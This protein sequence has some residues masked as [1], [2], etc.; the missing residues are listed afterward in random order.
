[1]LCCVNRLGREKAFASYR[2]VLLWGLLFCVLGFLGRPLYEDDYYRYL[3]DG[4]Q[5]ATTGNPYTQAPAHFAGTDLPRPFPEI[6]THVGFPQ[7]PTIYGPTCQL[8]FAA[9]YWIA[10]GKLWPLKLIGLACHFLLVAVLIRFGLGPGNL[11]LYLWSPLLFKEVFLTAH[12]DILV[13]C[14]S[15]VALY[16]AHRNRPLAAG[17]SLG[18]AIGAKVTILLIAPAVIKKGGWRSIV[19]TTAMLGALY[20]PFAKSSADYKG[21]AAFL[22]GWEFNSFGYAILKFFTGGLAAKW[23]G[24][25][26]VGL[27]V[28]FAWRYYPPEVR[29]FPA[30]MI[31]AAFYFFSPVVNPW[32]LISWLPWTAVQPSLWAIAACLAALLSYA[33]GNNM[34]ESGLTGYNHPPWVRPAELTIVISAGLLSHCGR[35]AGHFRSADPSPGSDSQA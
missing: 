34:P 2:Q 29:R 13:A 10:P 12:T 11:L 22:A 24:F 16:L 3:W 20:L 15:F 9:A 31:W 26:L 18:L 28:L 14:F 32:Y 6:L 30:H 33:T 21:L 27:V 25:S 19:A 7:I 4:R 17:A 1:M 5:F 35:F 23:I 8:A